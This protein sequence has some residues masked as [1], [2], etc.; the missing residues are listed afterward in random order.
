[1]NANESMIRLLLTETPLPAEQAAQ[2]CGVDTDS[3]IRWIT[4]GKDMG[5]GRVKL[6]GYHAGRSWMTTAEA[7]ARFLSASPRLPGHVPRP[8]RRRTGCLKRVIERMKAT[9]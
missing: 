9:A 3:V 1:M 8:A 7:L 6:E 2:R 5:Q 4:R